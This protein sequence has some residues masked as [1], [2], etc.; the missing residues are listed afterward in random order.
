MKRLLVFAIL[1]MLLSLPF[2]TLANAWWDASWSYRTCYMVNTTHGETYYGYPTNLSIDLDE[3]KTNGSDIRV[4]W[5]NQTDDNEILIGHALSNGDYCTAWNYT[6]ASGCLWANLTE[7]KN[8]TNAS[9]ICIYYTA[10]GVNDTSNKKEVF[11]V[12]DDFADA[13][14]NTTIWGTHITAGSITEGSGYVFI[15]RTGGSTDSNELFTKANISKDTRVLAKMFIDDSVNNGYR[16]HWSWG[17][18]AANDSI[19]DDGIRIILGYNPSIESFSYE[20]V[21][22]GGAIV[23]TN[24]LAVDFGNTNK[25]YRFSIWDDRLSLSYDGTLGWNETNSSN[26][27]AGRWFFGAAG[28]TTYITDVYIYDVAIGQYAGDDD[29]PVWASLGEESNG[30]SILVTLNSPNNDYETYEKEITFNYTVT[31]TNVDEAY[32]HLYVDD[33]LIQNDTISVT[34]NITHNYTTS[35]GNHTWYVHAIS[36]DSLYEDDSSLR[37]F[38]ITYSIEE[39]LAPDDGQLVY[40][41]TVLFQYRTNNTDYINCSLIVDSSVEA[42]DNISSSDIINNT[43]N[44]S[45]GSHDWYVLCSAGDNPDWTMQSDTWDFSLN[46]DTYENTINLTE[47]AEDV[48]SNPAFIFYDTDGHLSTFYTSFFDG[49]KHFRS[50]KINTSDNTVLTDYSLVSS[51]KDFKNFS[52]VF[53]EGENTTILLFDEDDTAHFVTLESNGNISDNNS[54]TSYNVTEN[55]FYNPYTYAYSKH[56]EDLS[57]TNE[58]YHLFFLPLQTYTA[59]ARVNVSTN[60]ITIVETVP[61]NITSPYPTLATSEDLTTWYY[62][63]PKI[64]SSV[65]T[66]ITLYSYN[67][68]DVTE[69]R[70]L[71]PTY[72]H[73]DYIENTK[74]LLERYQNSTFILFNVDTGSVDETYIHQYESNKTVIINENLDYISDVIFIDNE[75]FIFMNNTNIYS[76]YFGED[77]EC[78]KFSAGEY[79]EAM[80]YYRGLETTA[81]RVSDKD[82]VT[83]GHIISG[84]VVQLSYTEKEYDVKF[85]CYDEQ[86]ETRKPFTVQIYTDNNSVILENNVWGYAVTSENIGAG[87]KRA[88]SFGV[89]G[90]QRLYIVGLSEQYKIDLYSLHVDEGEY[91]TFTIQDSYGQDLEGVKITAYRFSNA[92]K[93][94]VVVEQALTD[95]SGSGILFLEPFTLYKITIEEDGYLTLNFEFIPAG[96][97]TVDITLSSEGEEPLRLPEFYY[98]WDDVAY[99]ISPDT[100]MLRNATNVSYQISSNSSKLEYFGMRIIRDYNG[101]KTTIYNENETS[102]PSGGTLLSEINQT[103]TYYVDTWFKHEDYDLYE[104][105]SRIYHYTNAT[106]GFIEA[107]DKF[108]EEQPI[109]GWAFYLSGVII[110]MVVVGFVSRY[111]VD[112]AG[113]AG[114][115]VLWGFTLFNPN[116]EL[117]CTAGLGA[118]ITPLVASILTTIVVFSAI[119]LRHNI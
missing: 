37:D 22:V 21:M 106:S 14:L 7:Y 30:T 64:H 11:E 3:V 73:N 36:N 85:I 83:T 78:I 68:T 76:C 6:S 42:T 57:L 55:T 89:N 102:S 108:N 17:N 93:A 95:Y 28:G 26:E 66:N 113:L 97:T 65:Y 18:D 79:G 98:V 2:T 20:Y 72:I 61:N 104:P 32:V 77:G 38:N 59:V 90:T 1:F 15:D 81:K 31:L 107:K 88:Y 9:K 24:N 19:V 10:T 74:I 119:Y 91:Y 50:Q 62:V 115:V 96:I 101:T 69:L 8:G 58:S 23:D 99:T 54:S 4:T 12:Y 117:V 82:V 63:R 111:T 35:Y 48:Y 94:W 53:R 86:N 110:S 13:S 84:D 27:Q 45:S 40:G 75:T 44:L 5:Y 47:S 52:A 112:G 116:V 60:D 103:G 56:Y 80:T 46:W 51:N 34:S 105:L 71:Y 39:L 67:G 49:D 25:T 118:C 100:Y 109:G 29:I 87:T 33:S 70:K 41:D 43:I 92:K 16:A 114:L